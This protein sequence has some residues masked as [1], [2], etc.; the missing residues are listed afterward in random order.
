M[1]RQARILISGAGVAGLAA[2]I[3][4]GR[5]GF[6]PTVVEKAPAIRADGYVISISNTAYHFAQELGLQDELHAAAAGHVASSYHDA[7]GRALLRLEYGELFR[8]VDVAQPMRDDFARLLERHAAGLAEFRYATSIEAIHD[9]AG[10]AQVRFDDA[11]EGEFDVVIGADGVH[12]RVREL[13]FPAD[14]VRRHRLGLGCAAFR[15]PNVLGLAGKF[16]THMERD[17]YMVAFSTP[18]G[19]MA[20]VFVWATD[21]GTVP[22]PGGRMALLR[23]VFA[24]PPAVVQRVLDAAPVQENMY[25]DVLAQIELQQWWRGASVLVGDA[26]H[27]MTLFSGQGASAA[28]SGAGHLC[29]GLVAGDREA[30][31]RAYQS[32][33]QP[34]VTDMQ[35]RTRKA[36]YW[37]V[38]RS[39]GREWLRNTGMAMLPNALF[40][41]YFRVKYSRV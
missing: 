35:R 9:D 28:F 17:R 18:D 1:D 16:E 27:C 39:A 31:F 26:A 38:P 4:L 20:A 6:R 41:N 21:A 23:E 32:A 22:A 40:R 15:L 36:A 8:R 12:S 25:M 10:V 14:A 13:A 2:A 33:M 11:S 7:S 19:G 30:A 5:N 29:K 34:A 37:Y 24:R 3:W